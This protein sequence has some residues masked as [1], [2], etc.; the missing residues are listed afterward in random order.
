[1]NVIMLMFVKAVTLSIHFI[2]ES[3]IENGLVT[4]I[5]LLVGVC[6]FDVSDF[7]LA[8]LRFTPVYSK[9]YFMRKI[10]VWTYF[11]AQMCLGL[12]ILNISV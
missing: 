7:T 8:L 1:M 11:F 6:M 10:N 9:S 3:P 4:G 2:K 5:I 12:T